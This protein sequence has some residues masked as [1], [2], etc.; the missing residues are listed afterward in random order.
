[1]KIIL[2]IQF[3]QDIIASKGQVKIGIQRPSS[4][5][6]LTVCCF[7]RGINLPT[8]L[9]SSLFGSMLLF[10]FLSLKLGGVMRQNL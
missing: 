5:H 7:I 8:K 6:F 4:F 10:G 3:D 9:S 2:F 1:M